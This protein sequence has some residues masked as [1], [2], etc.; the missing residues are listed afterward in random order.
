MPYIVD[1][2]TTNWDTYFEDECGATPFVTGQDVAFWGSASRRVLKIHGSMSNLG[3]LVVTQS[4]YEAR[5]NKL[6][7]DVMGGLLRQLLATRPVV[8]V[9]YSLRDWNFRRL[10]EALV[11]DMNGFAPEAYVVSPHLEGETNDLGMR[12][13]KTSGTAF[14]R[15]LKSELVGHCNVDD[16]SYDLVRSLYERVENVM[17][18]IGHVSHSDYPAIFY[19]W[20]Y[21]D[22]VRDACDRILHRRPRGEYSDRH[23]LVGLVQRYAEIQ[24]RCYDRG[25]YGDVAY[26]D[27][28]I[29]AMIAMT[30]DDEDLHEDAKTPE[31][32]LAEM[33]LFF[34]FNPST[35]MITRE[36][37]TQELDAS[38]R[39]SPKTRAFARRATAHLDEGMV[40]THGPTLNGIDG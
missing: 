33:P 6:G 3:S 29:N 1:I 27:G 36:E 40:L 32:R 30:L 19:T 24:D 2:V 14:L 15:K 26:I 11:S 5:L 38:R 10:Y 25:H 4:D 13:L 9:G 20:M 28:Y 8:F 12:V 37:F 21:H 23:R 17:E 34:F 22:G 35:D 31:E 16:S 39:R 18:S 7:T